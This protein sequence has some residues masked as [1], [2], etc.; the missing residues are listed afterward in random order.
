MSRR[1]SMFQKIISLKYQYSSKGV[2]RKPELPITSKL[3]NIAGGM[4]CQEK[5]IFLA[6]FRSEENWWK[7]A[8]AHRKAIDDAECSLED[9]RFV[10]HH[11][12]EVSQKLTPSFEEFLMKSP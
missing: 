1:C 8:I 2:D 5:K 9:R 12:H 10:V 4:A 3:W 7:A 11:L 6:V